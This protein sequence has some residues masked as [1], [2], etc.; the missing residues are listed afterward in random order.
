MSIRKGSFID[1][2]TNENSLGNRLKNLK[3]KVIK[4]KD[5]RF[6]GI[7]KGAVSKRKNY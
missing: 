7:T 1:D 5:G 4:S 3:N 2:L 6:H